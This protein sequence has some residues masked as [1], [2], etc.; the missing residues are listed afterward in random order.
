M[1]VMTTTTSK[2]SEPDQKAWL[3]KLDRATTAHE[4]TREALDGLVAD[5]R[6]AGVPLTAI[7]EHTPYSRE[8]VRKIAARVA[9]ERKEQRAD[10]ATVEE[11]ADEAP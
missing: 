9:A 1:P 5:A 6:A 4:K 3:K 10:V 7:S 11:G 8:W 2:P